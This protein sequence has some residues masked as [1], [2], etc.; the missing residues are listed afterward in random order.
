MHKFFQLMIET[1]K[2]FKASPRN[3]H[4]QIPTGISARTGVRAGLFED[5][6]FTEGI[7]GPPTINEVDDFASM[8]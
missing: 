3:I 2:L 4:E 7:T 6:H 5:G 8:L 1:V